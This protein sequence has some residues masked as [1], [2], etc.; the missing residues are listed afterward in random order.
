MGTWWRDRPSSKIKRFGI[1]P[2]GY[3]CCQTNFHHPHHWKSLHPFNSLLKLWHWHRLS[4]RGQVY[5]TLTIMSH[6]C[7]T[8]QSQNYTSEVVVDSSP[9]TTVRYTRDQGFKCGYDGMPL[10]ILA[11]CMR[12]V[13]MGNARAR[14]GYAIPSQQHRQAPVVAL[15]SL[16]A[17]LG[18]NM[19]LYNIFGHLNATNTTYTTLAFCS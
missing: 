17:H 1:F 12:R 18:I 4:R 2:H 16:S 8:C 10:K 19:Y 11:M 14:P 5:P 13:W 9:L 7:S 3:Y 15:Y 6:S